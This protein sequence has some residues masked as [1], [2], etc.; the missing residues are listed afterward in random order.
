MTDVFISY[1]HSTEG[2]AGRIAEALGAQGHGV[3]AATTSS[4]PT[5]ASGIA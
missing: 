1:A 5:R 3:L 2:Q 4:R